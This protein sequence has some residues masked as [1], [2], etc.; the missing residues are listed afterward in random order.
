MMVQIKQMSYQ[1]IKYMEEMEIHI[2]KWKKLVW[3]SYLLYD[4]TN[5]T[6]WKSQNHGDSKKMGG[7]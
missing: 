1:I 3:K 4:S 5:I 2:A 7:F 6:F